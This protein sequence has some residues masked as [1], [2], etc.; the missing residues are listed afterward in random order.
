MVPN[1]QSGEEMGIV[2]MI[3]IN[4]TPCY[5]YNARTNKRL[6][7]LEKIIVM[8]GVTMEDRIKKGQRY[9]TRR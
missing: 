3:Q 1:R 5:L 2:K 7:L 9:Q 4:P 6:A 8:D